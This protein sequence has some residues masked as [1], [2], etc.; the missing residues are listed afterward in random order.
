MSALLH[1]GVPVNN[2]ELAELSRVE[3]SK[4]FPED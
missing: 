4:I 3:F 1:R 2:L